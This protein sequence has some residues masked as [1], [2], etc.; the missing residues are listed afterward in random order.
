MTQDEF[1]KELI[2]CLSGLWPA[3]V[4]RVDQR[5]HPNDEA[6]QTARQEAMH[7]NRRIWGV[8]NRYTVRDVI[9]VCHEVASEVLFLPEK[10]SYMWL[11]AK[12]RDRLGDKTGANQS[13]DPS[14]WTWQDES[15]LWHIM[16]GNARVQVRVIKG[17]RNTDYVARRLAMTELDVAML[18]FGKN[19]SERER[20]EAYDLL[21]KH[22]AERRS[23]AKTYGRSSEEAERRHPYPRE[24]VKLLR[25]MGDELRAQDQDRVDA[26]EANAENNIEA[27]LN[28][29]L[30]GG[31]L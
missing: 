20:T 22:I 27:E 7:A 12:I 17:V 16:A 19:P 13:A 9:E 3:M 11:L 23:E 15:M 1:H 31:L 8:L 2:P 10:K 28:S 18:H 5:R 14:R 4:K 29:I 25:E 24:S 21:C 6:Y 30:G 26:D